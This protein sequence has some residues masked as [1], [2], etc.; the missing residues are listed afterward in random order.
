M[1]ALHISKELD[2]AELY[3]IEDFLARVKG[4]AIPNAET[5]DGFMTALV[6]CPDLVRPSEYMEYITSGET[7]DDDLVFE[8]VAEAE[9]LYLSLIHI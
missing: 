8:D 6:I 5:L 2:D 9:R 3:E 4:G 7:E 1:A